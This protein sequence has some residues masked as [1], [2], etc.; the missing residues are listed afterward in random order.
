[1]VVAIVLY[2]LSA[3]GGLRRTEPLAA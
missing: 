1:M 2:V 3:L